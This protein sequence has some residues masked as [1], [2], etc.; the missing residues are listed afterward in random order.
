MK[1]DCFLLVFFVCAI[2]S[3]SFSKLDVTSLAWDQVYNVAGYADVNQR[4]N[5]LFY[6]FFESRNDPVN[7][8]VILWLNGGP[9][10]SSMKGMM[11]VN[12]PGIIQSDL[13]HSYNPYSWNSNASVIWLDQPAGTGLSSSQEPVKNVEQL[14]KQVYEFLDQFFHEFPQYQNNKFHISGSS[15]AG[16]YVSSIGAEILRQQDR[17]FNFTSVS[18][19]NG[20]IDATLQYQYMQ[21][22]L[23]GSAGIPAVLNRTVC[24]RM[25]LTQP[26][27]IYRMEECLT[28]GQTNCTD[29]LKYCNEETIFK[30][31][32][33]FFNVNDPCS[34]TSV[35]CYAQDTYY[36]QYLNLP[37]VRQVLRITE[38]AIVACNATIYSNFVSTGTMLQSTTKNLGNLLDSGIPVI[39]MAGELDATYNWAGNRAIAMSI[40]WNGTD[41][42]NNSPLQPL[43][44]NGQEIADVQNHDFLTFIKIH[45]AGH[46]VSWDQP[47]ISLTLLN[48]WL[49][50]NWAMTSL[51]ER[52]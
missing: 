9:G 49:S 3:A 18:I 32:G 13:S 5:S 11:W 41:A 52:K 45:N 36:Q 7:D 50:G 16:L 14:S 8:P 23:C 34:N 10:C 46:L 38:E 20:L 40:E 28:G 31:Q 15:D 33:N 26:L 30:Y 39:I 51:Y 4:K 24:E 42:F 37:H 6:W 22:L 12:G 27:C 48:T 19:V 17:L 1:L 2:V 44:I 25:D 43:K 47:E 29:A 35:S 21:P